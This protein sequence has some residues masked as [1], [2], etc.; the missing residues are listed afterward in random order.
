MAQ[1]QS[2]LFP[3][4]IGAISPKVQTYYQISSKSGQISTP[5]FAEKYEDELFSL[6]ALF[7]FQFNFTDM[8]V[9]EI[10]IDLKNNQEEAFIHKEQKDGEIEHEQLTS[11]NFSYIYTG[12]VGIGFSR[13][14][15]EESFDVWSEK[16]MTGILIR[17][18][19][20]KETSEPYIYNPD[21]DVKKPM[22]L[23]FF[24]VLEKNIGWNELVHKLLD[25]KETVRNEE[26][27]NFE[28]SYKYDN[29]LVPSMIEKIYLKLLSTYGQ[30]TDLP[31][32]SSK[33]I[34]KEMF[35]RAFDFYLL[36]IFLPP[37]QAGDVRGFYD[38]ILYHQFTIEQLIKVL[39]N[40]LKPKTITNFEKEI[41]KLIERELNYQFK[42]EEI[43]KQMM[44]TDDF[45]VRENCPFRS[46]DSRTCEKNTI[47]FSRGTDLFHIHSPTS[48]ILCKNPKFQNFHDT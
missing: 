42:F 7:Y 41:L 25:T 16:R 38:N 48:Y 40:N 45:N 36:V 1:L 3:G 35:Q 18:T 24:L 37:K 46:N 9:I 6:N 28:Y 44:S 34:S 12:L 22:D 17:W 19:T 21:Y 47:V 33:D 5:L 29:V 10:E 30:V 8:T 4:L 20:K 11:G 27:A 31:A 13:E 2:D 23:F 32:Y 14:M 26:G 43:L 39:I 15:D